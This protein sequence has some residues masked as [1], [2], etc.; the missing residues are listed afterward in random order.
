MAPA[1]G[2]KPPACCGVAVPD[3]LGPGP[4]PPAEPQAEPPG[5]APPIPTGPGDEAPGGVHSSPKEKPS[6]CGPALTAADHDV[7]E[8]SVGSRSS[9]SLASSAAPAA[10]STELA[11][12]SRKSAWRRTSS[13]CALEYEPA[14]TALSVERF[15]CETRPLLTLIAFAVWLASCSRTARREAA[16]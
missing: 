1:T 16:S 9:I 11:T 3:P 14:P 5:G 13:R 12:A 4:P 10:P 8:T 7:A 2:P 15:A 6:C